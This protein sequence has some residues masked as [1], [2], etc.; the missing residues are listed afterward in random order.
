MQLIYC[1]LH[2]YSFKSNASIYDLYSSDQV[3]NFVKLYVT[4]GDFVEYF[5]IFVCL[6]PP[7]YNFVQWCASF[8]NRPPIH[9]CMFDNL[10]GGLVH[11][12][13]NISWMTH[14]Y[15]KCKYHRLKKKGQLKCGD[16]SS[17]KKVLTLSTVFWCPVNIAINPGNSGARV[18]GGKIPMVK[19]LCR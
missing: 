17:Q 18:S 13:R 19:S 16:N 1:L 6:C 3:I 7:L 15:H 4:F 11:L 10:S 5:K 12:V 14:K 9:L 2:V 8:Q